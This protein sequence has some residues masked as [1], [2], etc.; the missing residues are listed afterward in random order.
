MKH[1]ATHRSLQRLASS[2]V[3]LASLCLISGV[4][5]EIS[6][7][8]KALGKTPADSP[9]M[10]LIASEKWTGHYFAKGLAEQELNDLIDLLKTF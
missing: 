3:A 1:N 10:G 4:A 5:A 8:T 9:A 2:L 6:D 7:E